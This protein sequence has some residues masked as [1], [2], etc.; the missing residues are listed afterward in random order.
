MT[1]KT[2]QD[3]LNYIFSY[4]DISRTHQDNIA[5]ENFNLERMAGFLSRLGDPHQAYPCLH[6]AGTKGKGSVSALC[7]S[8][9]QAGD[10]KVG[11]YTSP[12]LHD[13]SERIQVNRE[14][15]SQQA[16]VALVEAI[17][18]V[19]AEVP[20]LT[21]YEI[22]TALAFW[23]FA[24]EEVDIAVVEVG[25]GG[26]L[27]STNVITPLVSVITSISL[28]HTYV[29][30][31]TLAQIAGEKGG[32]IKHGIPLVSAPQNSEAG[33]VLR[34]MADQKNSRMVQI[35]VDVKFESVSHSLAGQ[36]FILRS[37]QHPSEPLQ[38]KI[39]LLGPHQIENAAVAYAAL[40]IV[41][42]QGF[43]LS[44]ETIRTGFAGAEWAGRFEIVQQNPPVVFDGAHNQYS[45]MVLRKTLGTYFPGKPVTMIFGASEDKDIA[46]MFKE[47]LPYCQTLILVSS[48]HPRAAGT[49]ELARLAG[50]YDCAV[51][52]I[53]DISQAVQEGLK[54]ANRDGLVL[55]TGS[56]YLV[57][58]VREIWFEQFEK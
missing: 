33:Q 37:G 9:L 52:L 29:L 18:P 49:Q 58:E 7:A 47:L 32:I 41:R 34:E 15:I 1:E 21:S 17:K 14:P 26:R 44:D 27:D 5:P 56:L 50:E 45:A 54:L 38:F 42:Q 40:E 13:F 20:G 35:G 22:Q 3:A 19:A 43:P 6:I 48:S 2:Y 11:M 8:A 28:D 51:T 53:A 57:G 39:K 4:I 16:L 24:K 23:H 31:D 30:G 10:Y 46:G 12:H 36:E 25:L 55:A